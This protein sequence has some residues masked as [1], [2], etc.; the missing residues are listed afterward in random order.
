MGW[1]NPT[2]HGEQGTSKHPWMVQERHGDLKIEGQQ[3]GGGRAVGGGYLCTGGG[4]LA[5][6]TATRNETF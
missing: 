4:I 6:S 1:K 2:K 3:V 5:P